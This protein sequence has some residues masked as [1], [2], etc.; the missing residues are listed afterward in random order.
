MLHLWQSTICNLER[1]KIQRHVNASNVVDITCSTLFVKQGGQILHQ[2]LP[3][4]QTV[5]HCPEQRYL[6][7][8]DEWNRIEVCRSAATQSPVV[9]VKRICST[10]HRDFI[11]HPNAFM[12]SAHTPTMIDSQRDPNFHQ[13]ATKVVVDTNR[14]F[15]ASKLVFIPRP[16]Q[17]HLPHQNEH[18]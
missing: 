12:D 6:L 3:N 18:P 4:L 1:S 14:C 16:H 5:L 9:A 2:D 7:T 17:T 8:L 11:V 15:V 13:T 10:N